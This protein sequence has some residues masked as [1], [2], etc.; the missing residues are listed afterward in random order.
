MKPSSFKTLLG[1][2]SS[3]PE[4]ISILCDLYISVRQRNLVFHFL[5]LLYELTLLS[6]LSINSSTI[7]IRPRATIYFFAYLSLIIATLLVTILQYLWRNPSQK[8]LLWSL[9]AEHTYLA[10]LSFWSVVVTLNDQLG[11]NGLSVYTYSLL[12]ISILSLAKPWQTSL[13]FFLDFL[14]LNLLLPYF[15]DPNGFNH[16]YNNFI[17]SLALSGT[18]A[19]ITYAL[20]NSR[21]QTKRQE[22]FIQKQYEQIQSQNMLL[23]QEADY[24]SLT[25]LANRNAY[26]KFLISFDH[27]SCTSFACIYVDVNG[28]HERNNILGHSSGDSMLQSVANTLSAVF[29]SD[30][31]FR[32]GGD[33]FVLF[34]K[35]TE[36]ALIEHR[37]HAI[38]NKLEKETYS[39]SYGIAWNNQNIQLP[40]L[41]QTAELRMRQCKTDYYAN[42]GGERQKRILNQQADQILSEKKDMD[43]FLHILQPVFLGVYFV[44]LETDHARKV[45]I[46]PYFSEILELHPNYS[47][48]LSVYMQRYVQPSDFSLFYNVLDYTRLKQH[49]EQDSYLE[50]SYCKTDGTK[51]KLMISKFQYYTQNPEETVW[52]FQNEKKHNLF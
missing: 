3:T 6:I 31:I 18:A 46:P 15:P 35:N 37:F 7:F 45:F 30:D 4:D 20:Y 16:I 52:I 42:L 49:L 19:V 17:N 48:A 14:L 32:I 39:I 5:V 21:M 28:L 10:F 40:S 13:L 43:L 26:Q 22:L 29:P 47:E 38:C 34:C 2:S 23:R 36:L 1:I 9:R 51:I 25:G 33:E 8:K 50:Y 41:L 11:G 27:T 44:N 24:D 12:F